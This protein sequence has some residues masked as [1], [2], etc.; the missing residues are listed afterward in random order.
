MLI[1]HLIPD[2][3]GSLD[4][5]LDFIFDAHLLERLLDGSRKLVEELMTVGFCISQFFLD[6]VVGIRMLV[7]E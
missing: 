2:G 5:F 1:L 4:T 6:A 3:V 7:L